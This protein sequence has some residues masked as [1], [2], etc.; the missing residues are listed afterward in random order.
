MTIKDGDFIRIDYTEIV[1]GE[2]VASTN[3]DVALKNGIFDEETSYGPRLVIVGQEMVVPGFE[4]ELIGK[5]TGY[6]D[7][8]EVPPEKAFGVHDPKKMETYPITLFKEEKPFPGMNVLIDNRKGSVSRI[9]GRKV[10]V[11]FNFPLAGKT[12]KYEYKILEQI[13]SDLEKL[14]GLIKIIAGLELDVKKV[15]DAIEIDAPWEMNYY[16]EWIIGRRKLAEMIITLIHPEEVRFIER[17]T[18]DGLGFAEPEAEE[19][20]AGSSETSASEESSKAISAE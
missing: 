7:V 10:R 9:I 13:E 4:E 17:H 5:E 20:K 8:V 16:K 18:A 3:K 6:S 12:V 15:E 14:K 1:D 2:V 11:D 19:E